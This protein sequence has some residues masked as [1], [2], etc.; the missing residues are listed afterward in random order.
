VPVAFTTGTQLPTIENCEGAAMLTPG[1]KVTY[2]DI[3]LIHYLATVIKMDGQW[4]VVQWEGRDYQSKE[5]VPNLRVVEGDEL[6]ARA[7]W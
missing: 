7:N 2:T 4:A 1:A 5:W 3:N 6:A